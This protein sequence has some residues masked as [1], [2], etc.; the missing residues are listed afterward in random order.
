MAKSV[1]AAYVPLSPDPHGHCA[2]WSSCWRD[3]AKHPIRFRSER[4]K[5]GRY[6]VSLR[7]QYVSFLASDMASRGVQEIEIWNEPPWQDDSWDARGYLFDTLP[8]VDMASPN[9][10]LAA[11]LQEISLPTGIKLIW[12]GTEKSGSQSLM[13]A[14][15]QNPAVIISSRSPTFPR[16]HS[17]LMAIRRNK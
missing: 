5:P 2:E 10:G 8:A 6:C 11:N 17:T 4:R 15:Y 7:L 3:L 1:V 12:A 14:Q 9:Y 13:F 16:N